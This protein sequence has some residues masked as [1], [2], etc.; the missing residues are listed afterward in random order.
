MM[1]AVSGHYGLFEAIRYK[2]HRQ[3]MLLAEAGIDVDCRNERGQTPS[4]IH[5]GGC[6]R[7]Q[8]E[9]NQVSEAVLGG[10]GR[11]QRC[12]LE[13]VDGL[14]ARFDSWQAETVKPLLECVSVLLV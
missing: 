8:Q 7:L 12:G 13:R 9:S 10:R 2:R 1:A 14:D 5:C 6:G 11:S 3:A 4:H